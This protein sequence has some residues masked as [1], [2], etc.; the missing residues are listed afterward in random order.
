MM[1][2][3]SGDI[4]PAIVGFLARK[5]NI[6]VDEVER[7]LNKKSGLFGVSGLSQ[8]TRILTKQ[9]ATDARARLALDVFSYRAKKYVEELI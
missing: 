6:S 7:L 2:T 5:E 3:R 8:D 4:D 1:G 9:L